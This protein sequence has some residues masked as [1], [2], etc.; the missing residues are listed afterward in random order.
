MKKR[1]L[2]P[3]AAVILILIVAGL[4]FYV[5]TIISEAVSKVEKYLSKRSSMDVQIE[6]DINFFPPSLILNKLVF[7]KGKSTVVKVN[8]CVPENIP[9]LITGESYQMDIKCENSTVDLKAVLG[10]LKSF[11]KSEE[12]KA[13]EKIGRKALS[14]DLMIDELLVVYGDIR[15]ALSLSMNFKE[16]E[17]VIRIKNLNKTK[18]KGFAEILFSITQRKADLR[19]ESIELGSFSK[20][21]SEMTEI[22]LLE[23]K[24]SGTI[25]LSEKYGTVYSDNDIVINDFSIIHPLVDTAKFSIPF[26]RFVGK[27][28]ADVNSGNLKI[29]DTRVSLGGVDGSFSGNYSEK[30]R[31]FD[32]DLKKVELNRLETV[33]RNDVFKGYLFDGHIDLEIKYRNDEELGKSFSLIGDVIEPRQLSSR[34]NYL[35]QPFKYSF[36]EQSGKTRSFAVGP[37][38]VDYTDLVSIPDHL[39]WAVIVSEDAGFYVHQGIDFKEID[40]AVKDNMKKKK[41]RGGS[42]ITQ[43]LAKN[44][45]L[46]REKTMIRKLREAILAVEIDA[47][48]SKRRQLEI[49]LNIIEW[50]PGIF[51]IS[52]ASWYYFGK[53]PMEL[54]PL[55]SAYLA[56]I[57]PGP[58]KYNFQFRKK[59]V[60]EKWMKKLYKTLGLM[61]ETGHL[62]LGDYYEAQSEDLIFREN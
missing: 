39:K 47:A 7:S 34:L 56:S 36:T 31:S 51:G 5:D 6:A 35:S 43:Q 41:F 40:A 45:F 59:A 13:T 55:E 49:Y 23:G 61:N 15:E 30:S 18:A 29:K 38:N 44:L 37:S 19:F 9:E 3:V 46:K 4:S 20:L 12:K 24:M 27:S 58:I 57:I 25:K 10:F 22:E 26:L 16:N 21:I 60:S 54:T 17:G 48:L 52:E 1:I 50:G 33:V 42:T 14:V 28:I 32:L 11:Q 8:A 53:T 62:D 2:F